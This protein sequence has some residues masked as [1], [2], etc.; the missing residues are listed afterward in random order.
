[1]VMRCVFKHHVYLCVV[2]TALMA[3]LSLITSHTKA[4]AESNCGKG[5]SGVSTIRH[6]DQ[7]IVC[8]GGVTRILSSTSDGREI[9]IDMNQG[10][11]EAAVTVTGKGTNIT[12]LKK[13]TVT[14]GKSGSQNLPVI[15]VLSKG[16]LT[17]MGDVDVSRAGMIKKEIEVNGAG[18]SFTMHGE[19]K[20]FEGIQVK[21][22]G[23]IVLGDGVKTITGKGSGSGGIEMQGSGGTV[24]LLG[25]VAFDSV[26]AGIKIMGNGKANV[27]VKGKTMTVKGN[28][29]DG[30]NGIQ[31]EG[32]GGTASVMGLTIKG[33]GKGTGTGVSMGSTEGTL[34]MNMVNV[35]G[36]TMGV[37]A[38]KGKVN[39]NGGSTIEGSRMGIMVTGSGTTVNMM[40]GKITGSGGTGKG[41][42]V[43]GGTG[44]LNMVE[45]SK[46]GTG[47]DM[48]AGKLDMTKGKI[49]ITGSGTGVKVGESVT[50]ATIMGTTIEGDGGQ[51][52]GVQVSMGSS[53]KMT[54]TS[55]NISGVQT[56]VDVKKG[57]VNIKGDSTITVT[58]SGTGLSVTGG[59]VNMNMGTITVKDGGTGKGVSV[60]DTA[61]ATLMGTKIVGD[62]SGKG[63]GV[64]VSGTV[65][66]TSVGISGVQTGVK[67]TGSGTVNMNMGTITVKDGGM[68]LSV[69]GTGSAELTRTR[70]EG[71]GGKGK[72]GVSMGSAGGTLTLDGVNID[73]F[74]TGVEATKGTL[75]IKGDSTIQ[76]TG[77]YGVMVGESVTSATL[78]NVTI[79][80]MGSGKVG[81]N[82]MG[83]AMTLD[84][85][86]IEGVETGVEVKS[87][88][89]V[90]NGD[91][92]ITVKDGG[93][94]TG[95]MVGSGATVKMTGGKIVGM[96]SGM[97]GVQVMG[98]GTV[99]MTDVTISKVNIG[100]EATSGTVTIK[101]GSI[102]EVQTGIDMSG[103]GTLKISGDSKITF[104]GEH[105]V[106][107][108]NGVVDATL[109]SV[110]ITGMGSG[111]VG[112]NAMGKA[113]TLD[114]VTIEGVETGVEA[115]AGTLTIKDGT[116]ITF[117][118]EYG[119]KVGK[120]VESATLDGVTIMGD[121]SGM[122]SKGV[123]M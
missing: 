19:L 105:G 65:T 13:I 36:F 111:K 93:T 75:T 17:L 76:F 40:G 100:V 30:V 24:T 64:E 98:A 81:V 16:Q 123:L 28:G 1:M 43:M 45:I 44:I 82:A 46:F 74:K 91:S 66:M 9:E 92:K 122:G 4:Y 2:S 57:T 109:T 108:G 106:K 103:K 25:D 117:T 5:G 86:T 96:G 63:T 121:G 101:G 68:G 23:A 70:I 69:T 6:N 72:V 56:G 38:N 7:P 8:D 11:G 115:V 77:G 79:E 12:I 89:V 3:G 21:D 95:I 58:N 42:D 26:G 84:R 31:M 62:K 113:M 18:S 61:S 20:G 116:K 27:M 112:V 55:V 73:G 53:G 88:T 59:T 33:D 52:T 110:R 107:V 10:P 99:T 50:M 22:G 120:S 32:T 119:V 37:H 102:T 83:K 80:G 34:N 114:R 85:V 87:G 104:K 90:I 15:K 47:V 35:S 71:A 48:T 39:I 51:G 97:Y 60:Q 14:K 94:G 78:T 118:G 41:V 49:T 29:G 67:V 54:M